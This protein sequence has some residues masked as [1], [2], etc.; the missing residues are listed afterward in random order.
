[1]NLEDI[2]KIIKM[3]DESSLDELTIEEG[4]LKITLKR[5]KE[6]AIQNMPM[7][8]FS[9]P[10]PMMAQPMQMA[11]P[12]QPA[13]ETTASK[14]PETTSSSNKY[15]EIRSPMVGTF[16]R[17]PSPE[18]NPY[19]QKGDKVSKSKVLCIIEAMKL[20]NEIE[21]DIEGTIVDIL[22]ENGQPVEYDQVLFLIDPA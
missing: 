9:Q 22:V 11:Q 19:A 18:A 13:A 20:M 5:S 14:A 10:Q 3:L 17:A 2:Q 12:P 4:E 1:M 21:C 7:H 16:Y 8:G 6:V 15:K